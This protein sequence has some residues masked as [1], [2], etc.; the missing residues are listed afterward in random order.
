MKLDPSIPIAGNQ[1]KRETFVNTSLLR[2]TLNDD[3]ISILII[4][5]ETLSE[6]VRIL[7]L[8]HY[9]QSMV[10]RIPRPCR[11]AR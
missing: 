1:V 2:F 8:W 6:K 4:R 10:N 9:N 7:I 11:T 3:S 5:N